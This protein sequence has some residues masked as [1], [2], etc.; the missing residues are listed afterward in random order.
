MS[1]WGNE[2]T[3]QWLCVSREN[4]ERG[5]GSGIVRENMELRKLAAILVLYNAMVLNRCRNWSGTEMILSYVKL[6]FQSTQGTDT[7]RKPAETD[8]KSALRLPKWV[9]ITMA[10]EKL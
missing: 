5:V 7:M 9:T 3:K 4:V 2:K 8:P 6:T 10:K 1:E